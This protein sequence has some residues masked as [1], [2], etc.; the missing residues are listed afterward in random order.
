MSRFWWLPWARRASAT[1][2]SLLRGSS[3]GR[4]PPT[5]WAWR[6]SRVFRRPAWFT[7]VCN[8]DTGVWSWNGRITKRA[9]AV[10]ALGDRD[11]EVV[12]RLP[13]SLLRIPPALNSRCSR[14]SLD[15]TVELRR[16][17]RARCPQDLVG[18]TQFSVL[19]FEFSDPPDSLA[20][21]APSP[22]RTRPRRPL[23]RLSTT[24]HCPTASR[25]QESLYPER[26]TR[27][28]PCTDVNGQT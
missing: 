10:D 8:R 11:L 7:W 18:T 16:D 12:D 19:T 27:S 13:C 1:R 17:K 20:T 6:S 22:S 3:H 2:G 5:E 24:S 28:C 25:S 26:Q 21:S 4:I 9:A 15:F 14:R 23:P